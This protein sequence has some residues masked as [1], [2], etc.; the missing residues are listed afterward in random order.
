M[1]YLVDGNNLAHALGL[2]QEGL[3][4]R[5]ACARAVAAFCRSHGAQAT[6]VFDGP[7]PQGSKTTSE[8]HRVRI[9]FGEGRSADDIILR[10]LTNSKTPGD[11]TV[12]TSDKS[13]GDKARHRGASVERAHEFSRRLDR[14]RHSS[15]RASE[16]PSPRESAEQIEAWLAVFDPMRR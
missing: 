13:L 12:V 9:I 8:L 2:A 10:L 7:A 11:F 1:P 16:K 14:S 5:G 6:I 3:A 15:P 4:D